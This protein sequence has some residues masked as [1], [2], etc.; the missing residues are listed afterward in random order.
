MKFQIFIEAILKTF[1]IISVIVLILIVASGT[2]S[3]LNSKKTDNLARS[4]I[5]SLPDSNDNLIFKKEVNHV[6]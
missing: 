1:L 2:Q 3:I 6:K 5:I 4:W